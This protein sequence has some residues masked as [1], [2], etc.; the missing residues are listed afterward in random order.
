M[1]VWTSYLKQEAGVDDCP[2]MSCRCVDPMMGVKREAAS[3]SL[4]IDTQK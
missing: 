3:P 4:E 1:E 2:E